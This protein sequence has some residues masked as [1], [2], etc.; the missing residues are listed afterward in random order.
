M[1]L[2]AAIN[3]TEVIER[4]KRRHSIIDDIQEEFLED[5]VDE[6]TA[7][8]LA[9]A[10][11]VS[12]KAVTEVPEKHSFIIRGVA[13]KQY[14]RRGSEGLEEETVDGYKATYVKNDFSEYQ[15]FILTEYTPESDDKRGKA[16]FI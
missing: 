7:Y 16:V 11:E 4:L 2:M 9:I 8:Y 13:S 1:M 14:T 12:D 10:N 5:V 3:R 6:V 15:S